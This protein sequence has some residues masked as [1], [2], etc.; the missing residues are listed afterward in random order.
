MGAS[1]DLIPILMGFRSD[2][3]FHHR[4]AFGMEP[5]NGIEVWVQYE[6]GAGNVGGLMHVILPERERD[7][8]MYEEPVTLTAG[9]PT[10]AN[11][12]DMGTWRRGP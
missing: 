8:C 1:F 5:K 9:Q 4:S 3:F 11:R 2:R 6:R 12:C 10:F 7:L